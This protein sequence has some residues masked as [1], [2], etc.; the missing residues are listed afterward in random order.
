MSNEKDLNYIAKLEKAISG[1]YG[2]E[3][4]QNPKANWDDE[5]E[6]DYLEQLEE[7]YAIEKKEDDDK[8]EVDG[9]FI[10]RKLIKKDTERICPLCKKYSFLTKD[11]V[12]MRKF[13]C[14]HRCFLE[15]IDGKAHLWEKGWRPKKII[16]GE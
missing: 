4:I 6:K 2:K 13:N 11:D 14:C 3:A 5:K 16:Q 8:V 1:K 7:I 15:N 9:V 12:Y 10:P